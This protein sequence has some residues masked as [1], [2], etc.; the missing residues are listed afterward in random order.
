MIVDDD[1]GLRKQLRWAFDG[2]TVDLAEDRRSALAAHARNPSDVVLL[3]LGMPPDVDGPSEGLATLQ[4]ILDRAPHTK[5][6]VM[7][8]QRERAYALKAIA[9]GAYDYYEKPVQLEEIALIVDRAFRLAALE[10]ENRSL[11]ENA[12]AAVDGVITCNPAMQATCQ[13]IARF[14]RAD[15][16]VLIVGESGTGKELLA[17][18]LHQMAGGTRKGEYVGLNCAAIPENLLESELFGY[19]KGAFTGAHKTNPGRIEQAQNGTLMLDELGDLSLPLQVK[20][21]RV[22]QERS[23]ERVGGRKSIPFDT[24]I[25]SATNRDLTAMVAEGTFREDLYFRLAEAVVHVPA[26]RERPEDI[27]LIA[28]HFLAQWCQEQKLAARSFSA[29]ALEALNNHTWPGNVRELQ[30]RIKRAAVA[31]DRVITAEDLGLAAAPVIDV[32]SLKTIRGRAE[33]EAVRRALAQSEGNIS[34]AARLLDVSRP[35]LYQ[36]LREQGLR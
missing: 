7:T 4:E 17:R 1:P 6:I 13:Q 8:G 10:A 34:E 36:L 24:R 21:L 15:L 2:H 23:F 3:D 16:S 22:L 35:T 18:G 33:R 9:L 27:L 29:E 19:E 31:A 32:E 20:L 12:G 11:Q 28:Q 26:L 5:V 25:V 14:A 30:S